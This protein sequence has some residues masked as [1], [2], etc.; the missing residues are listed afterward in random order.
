MPFAMESA[1]GYGAF[2]GDADVLT[3]KL[4]A[5]SAWRP[6]A[7]SHTGYGRE[8]VAWCDDASP[9]FDPRFNEPL[10]A[11]RPSRSPTKRTR[12]P[13]SPAHRSAAPASPTTFA[14]PSFAAAPK[15]EA[16]PIPASLMARARRSPSPPKA[17]VA[18]M[19]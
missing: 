15:P 10:E 9:A 3:D 11:G 1:K 17:P 16:I 5:A 19:A 12:A 2:R 13:A 8:L 14:C 7:G 18:V 4:I 6:P